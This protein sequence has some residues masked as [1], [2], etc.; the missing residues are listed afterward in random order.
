MGG[1]HGVA[2][3]VLGAVQ[4]LAERANGDLSVV[5]VGDRDQIQKELAPV[6]AGAS[7]KIKIEHAPEAVQMHD[8]ATQSLRRRDTSIAVC[9]RLHKEGAVQGVVSPG[10]TGAVMATAL[11]T[12]QRLPNVIRP[13][14]ASLF[15]NPH[16]ATVVLDV[17]ANTEC[18]PQHLLQFAVMGS[19]FSQLV[20]K[21]PRPQVGL[22]SIGEEATK[23][24]ELTQAAH[25]MLS[26]D[27]A[28]NFVGNI[29]GRDVL[30]GEI[31]VAVTDGFVGNILL[32]FAE[33]VGPLL[34][35]KLRHQIN[36]NLFSRF[37]AL[38]MKPFLR[39]LRNSLDYAE[40][41]GAPLLGVDGVVI[42]CHGASGAKA[43]KNAVFEAEK[44]VRQKVNLH[45]KEHLKAVQDVEPTHVA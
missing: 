16:S 15:P 13:A 20:L 32:K 8:S 10:N 31:Q 14:I 21:H 2:P 39:R 27:P 41:G 7:D 35:T 38:L 18:K 25:R 44:S 5:L 45:I 11:L 37:G 1:D 6:P 12:L 40:Y 19:S 43:I 26:A 24:T 22:L 3:I 34:E 17:G 29:E 4:A 42:I 33:S 23:G 36:T 9:M 28:V 30:S